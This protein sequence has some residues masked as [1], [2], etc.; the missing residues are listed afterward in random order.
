MKISSY[1]ASVGKCHRSHAI[2]C[3][4]WRLMILPTNAGHVLKRL[5]CLKRCRTDVADCAMMA[6][7]IVVD[8]NVFKHSSPQFIS[9]RKSFSMD[10][11]Y[12]HAVKE[13]LGIW[14]DMTTPIVRLGLYGNRRV[15]IICAAAFRMWDF[16]C[17]GGE[18]FLLLALPAYVGGALLYHKFFEKLGN[19]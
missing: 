12:L 19:A 5:F 7:S 17:K 18:K 1:V 8:L 11:F 14:P 16:R 3:A 10:Q 4:V 15:L 13:T 9:G 6:L 2:Q